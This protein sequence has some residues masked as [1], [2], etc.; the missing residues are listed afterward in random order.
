MS[1]WAPAAGQCYYT[2]LDPPAQPSDFT[3]YNAALG[4]NLAEAGRLEALRQMLFAAKAAAEERLARV[5]APVLVL[6]GS[7][8][9]DFKDPLAEAQFVAD[10]LRG[11]LHLIDGAGHYPQ[12]E[13]PGVTAAHILSFIG[14][15]Q[16]AREV[17]HA[18]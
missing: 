9:P 1:T 17:H 15:L 7:K 2:T 6:M 13:M 16:P 4:K 12:A 10:S 18:A 8:D 14:T 5:Q 11:A 3:A